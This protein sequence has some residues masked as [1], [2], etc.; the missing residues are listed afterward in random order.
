[1]QEDIIQ[2]CKQYRSV[3]ERVALDVELSY[4]GIKYPQRNSKTDEIRNNP[5]EKVVVNILKKQHRS[6]QNYFLNNEPQISARKKLS[7]SYDDLKKSEMLLRRDF[8][9]SEFYEEEMDNITN[10][11]M[12]R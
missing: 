11:G 12:K 9:E 6:I 3:W 2:K 4:Q 1:M 5:K 10:Y 8:V 7:M